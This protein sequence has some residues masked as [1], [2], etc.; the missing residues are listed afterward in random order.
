MGPRKALVLAA[1][2]ALLV[3]ACSKGDPQ[4]MN[5]RSSGTGPDEFSIL[6]TR[7]I[8]IPRDVA[9]LPEPTPGGTNRTDPNP[10]ADIAVALGGRERPENQAVPGSDA[11]LLRT[12][13]RF[14]VSEGI[15]QT[16]AAED[17]EW[18]DKHRGRLLERIFNV[19]V[20]YRSYEPMSLDRYKELE[21]MRRAGVRTPAA[22]PD[23]SN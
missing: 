11:A 13:G 8:E 1:I 9:E 5:L 6:P 16:L 19:T 21:R 14:G 20:Y 7:P 12:T 15:R 23:T 4:L 2:A 22:P 17:Y 10:D 3:S 18:R